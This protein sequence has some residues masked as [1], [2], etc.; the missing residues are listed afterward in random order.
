MI[1]T[2]TFNP[3]IDYVVH[4]PGSLELD[5]VNRTV[6]E[7]Y[8]FGGKGI[9]VSSVLRALDCDN[10]ALGFV[11][12]PTG[13]WLE[14][15]LQAQGV[16]TDFIHLNQGVTRINVKILDEEETEVNG[17][18]PQPDAEEIGTLMSMLDRLGEG[19]VLVMAGSVPKSVPDTIYA[20]IM[21][22]LS[23]RGVLCIVDT[24]GSP[25]LHVL[26]EKPFLI[27]PNNHELGDIF[28][29]T[30][31]EKT[32]QDNARFFEGDINKVP[33]H[34]I[35]MGIATIMKAKKILLVATGENKADAIKAMVEGEPTPEWPASV[36][37]NHQDVVVIVDE[38]AAS[39]LSR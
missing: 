11:A 35:T 34:A 4:L 19:D 32:R 3:A 5:A 29:V 1:Y 24:S 26:E 27:K 15:G 37:Q 36:L 16:K 31:T 22:R 33:T 30:L 7:E 28:G 20:Q 10:T 6:Q 12:G 17:Q 8:L 39:K 13:H 14:T 23:G 18:G 9:N 25:F 38:A 2:V 21:K